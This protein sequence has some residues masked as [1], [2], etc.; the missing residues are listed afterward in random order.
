MTVSSTAKV[1]PDGHQTRWTAAVAA[2]GASLVEGSWS[3]GK[4]PPLLPCASTA[5][6]G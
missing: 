4:T 6:V 1:F 3:P 2:G 5:F